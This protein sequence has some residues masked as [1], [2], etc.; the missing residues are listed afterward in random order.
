[1]PTS[2]PRLSVTKDP[3]LADAIDRGRLLLGSRAPEA[4]LVHDLAVHGARLLADED[5]RR[6]QALSE[7]ASHDWLD[8]MLDS[9]VLGFES[10][11]IL[12]RR[13]V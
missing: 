7:L 4:T 3:V 1:M 8:E 6:R 5:E 9:D 13:L 10:R 11:W 12:A 2:R